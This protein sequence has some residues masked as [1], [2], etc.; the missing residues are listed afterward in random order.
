MSVAMWSSANEEEDGLVTTTLEEGLGPAPATR[1]R[2]RSPRVGH[3]PLR[4]TA[5]VIKPRHLLL[6]GAGCWH[7]AVSMRINVC[8]LWNE[9]HNVSVLIMGGFHLLFYL[10]QQEGNNASCIP[11]KVFE[12]FCD[13]VLMKAE[14][15]G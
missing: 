9:V 6:C 3:S 12:L 13:L 8:R 2:Q 15:M 1:T 5:V 14:Q 7:T 11:S 10:R 4:P